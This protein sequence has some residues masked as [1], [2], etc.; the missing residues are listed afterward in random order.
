MQNEF[1]VDNTITGCDTE[2]AAVNYYKTART[3]ISSAKFNLRSWFSHSNELMANAVHDSTADEHTIV[4]ILGLRWNLI[5][6][7]LSLVTK[8]LLPT[9]NQLVTKREVL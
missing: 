7:L 3:T 1:Y 2:S 6:D 5:T 9:S 4:N 8:P